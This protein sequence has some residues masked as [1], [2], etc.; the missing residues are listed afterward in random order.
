MGVSAF[1]F[2]QINEIDIMFERMEEF[3]I[4]ICQH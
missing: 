1:V 3:I 4:S 2:V